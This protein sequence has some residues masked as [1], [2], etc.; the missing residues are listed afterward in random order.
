MGNQGQLD[1]RSQ[2]QGSMQA[3]TDQ[4]V[5]GTVDQSIDVDH[6]TN[7]KSIQEIIQMNEERVHQQQQEQYRYSFQQP[8]DVL[9]QQEQHIQGKREQELN[10]QHM[11]DQQ[12]IDE[13]VSSQQ[14]HQQQVHNPQPRPAAAAARTAD[15]K[16]Q[17]PLL[18]ALN[19]PPLA[20]GLT[21]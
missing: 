12:R 17:P 3:S 10:E 8:R 6:L 9:R 18:Q 19:C 21:D 11:Q 5:E 14:T 15:D 16:T 7:R 13:Q 4:N 20:A 1:S 2:N